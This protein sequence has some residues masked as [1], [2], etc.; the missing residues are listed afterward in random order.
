VKR[1]R[2]RNW[3]RKIETN[4]EELPANRMRARM[5]FPW[6]RQKD[7]YWLDETVKKPI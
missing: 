6:R 4:R 5:Y 2:N 7:E 1:R 3:L